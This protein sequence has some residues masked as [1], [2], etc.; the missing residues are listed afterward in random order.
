MCHITL[1]A[2]AQPDGFAAERW[3]CDEDRAE[4]HP[5]AVEVCDALDNDCDGQ[6]D[7]TTSADAMTWYADGDGDGYGDDDR[8][9]VSCEPPGEGWLT[10]DVLEVFS[11]CNGRSGR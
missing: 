2:C 5:G 4:I 7:E 11:D 10:F 1:E 6:I 9:F 8:A 3:D